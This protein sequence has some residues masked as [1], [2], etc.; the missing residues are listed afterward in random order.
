M[1]CFAGLNAVCYDLQHS[2]RVRQQPNAVCS[3]RHLF[4]SGGDDLKHSIASKAL[5]C[6]ALGDAEDVLQESP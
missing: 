3:N 5:Y 1:V 6:I 4:A 2:L